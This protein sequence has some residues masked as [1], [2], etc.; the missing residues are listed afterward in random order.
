MNDTFLP[1]GRGMLKPVAKK[2]RSQSAASRIYDEIRQQIVTF[3]I[4]PGT[5]LL[6]TKLSEQYQVSQTPIREAMLRLEQDGLI[7][8]YPQSKTVVSKI[9]IAQIYEAHFLRVALE[10]EVVWRLAEIPDQVPLSRLRSMLKMQGALTDDAEDQIV[11]GELDGYFHSAMFEAA[12]QP[13]LF[14]LLQSKSGHL[15]RIQKLDLPKPGKMQ[16][17]VT[18]HG[19]IVDAIE[20][21]DAQAA[22]AAM[23]AHLSGS[24]SRIESL[25]QS[26]PDYFQ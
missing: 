17:A 21:G 16:R 15:A 20:N 23:R 19:A 13:H 4:P 7:H 9:D 12:G 25:R 24:I 18:A 5:T 10:C 14:D 8:T 1:E 26:H 22:Q 3:K 2:A 11:F 6:R